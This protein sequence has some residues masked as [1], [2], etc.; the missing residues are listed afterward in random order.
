[1]RKKF[2]IHQKSSGMHAMSAEMLVVSCFS[3]YLIHFV[4]Y[5]LL[6]DVNQVCLSSRAP[7]I[8]PSLNSPSRLCLIYVNFLSKF[9]HACGNEWRGNF[10]WTTEKSRKSFVFEMQ[11]VRHDNIKTLWY[12][13]DEV[14]FFPRKY[15]SNIFFMLL[16]W[17][18]F[19]IKPNLK[20]CQ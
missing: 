10:F 14:F 19:L 7:R 15:F 9:L 5:S 18:S 20:P 11:F 2:I 13:I 12:E 8:F 16:L 6:C 4:Y 3:K 1:M 17:K